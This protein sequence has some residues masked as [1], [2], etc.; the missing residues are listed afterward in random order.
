MARVGNANVMIIGENRMIEALKYLG[1]D[2]AVP[3]VGTALYMVANKVFNESQRQVPVR[4]GALRSS[5]FVS[6]YS[7]NGKTVHVR[8]SY[9]NTAVA[10]AEKQH[11]NLTFRHAPGRKALYLKDPMDAATPNMELLL[12]SYLM[13]LVRRVMY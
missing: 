2:G 13:R 3:A 8:I 5:G 12:N 1:Q 11:D 9:G 6:P 7:F 4:T 10:Y